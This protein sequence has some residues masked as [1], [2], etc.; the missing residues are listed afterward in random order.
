MRVQ[1]CGMIKVTITAFLEGFMSCLVMDVN[2]SK[3]DLM[4][5]EK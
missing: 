2:S 1:Y 5:L 4:K 3:L